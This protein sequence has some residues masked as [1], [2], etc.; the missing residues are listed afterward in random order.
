MALIS[1]LAVVGYALYLGNC[2]VLES[3]ILM[4]DVN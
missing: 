3:G 2:S 4:L 1:L